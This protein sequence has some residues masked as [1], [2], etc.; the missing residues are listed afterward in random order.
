[1]RFRYGPGDRE[2]CAAYA[3]SAC[4]NQQAGNLLTWR[5]EE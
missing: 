4:R 2:V 5:L 1:M 3:V